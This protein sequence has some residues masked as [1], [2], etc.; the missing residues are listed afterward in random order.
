[1]PSLPYEAYYIPTGA[2]SGTTIMERR[3]Q[4]LSS[5]LKQCI[6][7][8]VCAF[9]VA[10]VVTQRAV[11]RR[12][13][14][15]SIRPQLLCGRKTEALDCTVLHCPTWISAAGPVLTFSSN[16]VPE[17]GSTDFVE[18]L[19]R[20]DAETAADDLFHDLGG[21]AEDRLD[22]AEPPELTI[23]ADSSG[24]VLPPTGRVAGAET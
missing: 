3:K 24:L 19:V 7:A 9:S 23:V 20:L 6:T 14:C 13:R 12:P 1:M 21:A 18:G 8:G 4:A 17:S 2:L 11:D 22:A 16:I 10:S 5:F 15:L